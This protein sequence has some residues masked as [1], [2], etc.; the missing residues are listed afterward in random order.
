MRLTQGS[1]PGLTLKA[2]RDVRKP[3]LMRRPRS[4]YGPEG[5]RFTDSTDDS[6]PVNPGNGVEGKILKTRREPWISR[7][8]RRGMGSRGREVMVTARRSRDRVVR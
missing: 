6:G 7:Y 1:P 5:G 8:R 2:V 4:G 3:Y